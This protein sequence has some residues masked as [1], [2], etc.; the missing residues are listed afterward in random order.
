MN[1]KRRRPD[2]TRK[3]IS[4]FTLNLPY[5]LLTIILLLCFFC[6]PSAED[7]AIN[8]YSMNCRITP[9]IKAFYLKEGSRYFSFPIITVICHSRFML[10]HYWILL[11]LAPGL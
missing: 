4:L 5:L 1:K 11:L 9:F 7:F 8:Y 2:V 10:D 3:L 6:R